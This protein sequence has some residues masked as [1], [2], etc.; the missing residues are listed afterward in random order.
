MPKIDEK[1]ITHIY[2][3]S[4]SSIAYVSRRFIDYVKG[5]DWFLEKGLNKKLKLR[6]NNF[7]TYLDFLLV[8][9]PWKPIDIRLQPQ[10]PFS[11]DYGAT[12]GILKSARKIDPPNKNINRVKLADDA[13][14]V[15]SKITR[16]LGELFSTS[17][18]ILMATSGVD[19]DPQSPFVGPHVGSYYNMLLKRCLLSLPCPKVLFLDETKWGFNFIPNNCHPICDSELTW[20]Y[21]RNDTPLAIAIAADDRDKRDSLC[22]SLSAQGFSNQE[23][24][25]LKQGV[26]GVWPIIAGN[27]RFAAHFG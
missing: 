25:E 24:G 16:E 9:L 11:N 26:K 23:C 8:D 6:T 2:F 17:G 27:D 19:T 18:L 15:V 22:E 13:K 21:L 5:E 10:G 7:L 20:D 4:G 1:Q 14:K 12:Y 3:E